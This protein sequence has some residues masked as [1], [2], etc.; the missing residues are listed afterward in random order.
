MTS[1]GGIEEILW[2]IFTYYTLNSNP[3][4]PSKIHCMALTKLCKEV[5]LLDSSMTEIPLTQA[6]IQ[7]IYT[8]ATVKNS[9]KVSF[10][11]YYYFIILINNFLNSIE[12]SRKS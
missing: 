12:I 11:I 1:G 2:N 6:D 4:D 9:T 5:S 8:S 7:L 3:R 10:L